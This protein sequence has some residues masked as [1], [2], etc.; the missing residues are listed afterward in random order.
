MPITPMPGRRAAGV[1]RRA[2][3]G[4][5]GALVTTL[6]LPR[7]AAAASATRSLGL[8]NSP[9]P[10]AVALQ[11][12]GWSEDGWYW[13]QTSGMASARRVWCNLTDEGGGWML[14]AYAP[15]F[16]TTGARYPNV[17]ENGQGTLDRLAVDTMELWFHDGVPQCDTVLKMASTTADREPLLSQ[18]EIANR[19]TYSNPESVDL[20]PYVTAAYAGTTTGRLD[21]TWNPV[22]GHT[23]MAGPLTVDAPR[24]WI[25][26]GSSWWTVCGPATELTPDGRSG[27]A[28]GTG[29]WTNPTSSSVYGVADV[30]AGS[31]SQRTD[32]RTYAV[33]IR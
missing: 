28:Q 29:S 15:S 8:E 27:N 10:S 5:A 13:I 7:A 6:T 14:I 33:L 16:N 17:W 25:Y 21:G 12:D 30:A 19:V 32:V 3:V 20:P 4:G 22:K 26:S 1:P 31:N 24:D 18:V 2:V 11:E 23:Q 9:A